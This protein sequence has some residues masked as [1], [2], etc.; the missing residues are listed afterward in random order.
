MEIYGVGDLGAEEEVEH[1][2]EG[3]VHHGKDIQETAVLLHKVKHVIDNELIGSHTLESVDDIVVGEEVQGNLVLDLGKL[4]G[5]VGLHDSP[6]KVSMLGNSSLRES[7][8]LLTNLRVVLGFL[9]VTLEVDLDNSGADKFVLLVVE[10]R[11]IG[12]DLLADTIAGHIIDKMTLYGQ[13]I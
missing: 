2:L 4:S 3:F 12:F 1:T 5:V 13:H 11:G 6:L 9:E 8:L 7:V 10:R